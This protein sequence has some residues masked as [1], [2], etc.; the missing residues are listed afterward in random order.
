MYVSLS[1]H[2]Y[3]SESVPLES[4]RNNHHCCKT[5]FWICW[6]IFHDNPRAC[7]WK[8]NQNTIAERTMGWCKSRQCPSTHT[9]GP[10]KCC[11]AHFN[12]ICLPEQYMSAAVLL[13]DV[14]RLLTWAICQSLPVFF[15]GWLLK[16]AHHLKHTPSKMMRWVIR[17]QNI[18]NLGPA[19][20]A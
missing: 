14:K 7:S 10:K 4:Y 13:M 9:S 19:E 2:T 5:D 15:G 16:Q 3:G 17:C 8:I 1:I 18:V 12:V 20:M 6:C 11:W